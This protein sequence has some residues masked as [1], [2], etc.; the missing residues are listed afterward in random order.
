M[1]M[2]HHR[3]IPWYLWPFWA[4]WKLVA[5][6]VAGHRAV[7]GGHPWPGLPDRW[8]GAYGH[9]DRG[10]RRDPVH[11]LWVVSDG[12]GAILEPSSVPSPVKN[13]QPLLY[14]V[15]GKSGIVFWPGRLHGLR[16][17]H[18]PGKIFRRKHPAWAA[19]AA[20]CTRLS[21]L[22]T[23]QFLA[24]FPSRASRTS[25]A[26]SALDPLRTKWA[27]TAPALRV[28]ACPGGAPSK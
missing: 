6:I 16:S 17:G 11:Y 2:T 1:T 23:I 19:P 26:A 5:G 18:F 14:L 3:H 21:E 10:D 22:T 4:L 15:R 28:E 8:C 7:G 27:V 9:R 25:M 20:P 24:A 12:P 13:I